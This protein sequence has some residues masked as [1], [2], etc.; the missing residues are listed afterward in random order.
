MKLAQVMRNLSYIIVERPDA[1]ESFEDFADGLRR[2][3]KL[4]YQGVELHLGRPQGFKIDELA[5]LAESIDLPIVSFMTGVN[6]FGEGLCLSSP[7]AEVRHRTVER[8][9]E[10]TEIAARFGALLVVSQIQGFLSDEPDRETGEARIEEGLKR[11]AEAAER[12]GTT[13]AFEPVNHLQVGF[14]NTLADVMALADRI[15]STHLKPMLDTIHMNIEEKS[16]TEPIHRLGPDIAHFHLCESNGDL[17][18]S[19]HLDF[20]AIFQALD[21]VG[22]TGFTSVKVYRQPLEAGAEHAI[23]F[24]RKM[25][26]D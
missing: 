8:L 23:R 16:L 11:V 6:Y 5:R 20:K 19:G 25:L 3:K 24:L 4:G 15:G 2:I 14:N 10:Y 22:Y 21:E 18:G 9:Q 17:L 13:I 7:Q 12:H 1:F 26:G